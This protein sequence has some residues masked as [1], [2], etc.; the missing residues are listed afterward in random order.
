[1]D[2]KTLDK[3]IERVR[4][5]P[6]ERQR[7]AAE[8][9]LEMERQDEGRHRLSDAQVNEVARIQHEFAKGQGVLATDE[10]MAA[11]WKSCG[12]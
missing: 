8:V 9:L 1:M 6:K 5:W 4:L 12:L 2:D 3:V 7:D 10:E 11:L